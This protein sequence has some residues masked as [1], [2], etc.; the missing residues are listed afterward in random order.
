[1]G[2]VTGVEVGGG[3]VVVGPVGPVIGGVVVG[4]G[5]HAHVGQ[6]VPVEVRVIYEPE[7]HPA[8]EYVGQCLVVGVTVV[9]LG[10]HW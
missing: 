3:E 1:M 2:P 10:V 5:A 7:L 4:Y 9:F 6:L 8:H